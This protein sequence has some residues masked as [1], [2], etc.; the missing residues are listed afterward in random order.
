MA[1]NL[2]DERLVYLALKGVFQGQDVH[3]RQE[4]KVRKLIEKQ[5]NHTDIKQLVQTYS[6]D[7]LCQTAKVLLKDQVFESTLKAK[8]R[9]PEVFEVSPDQ[10]AERA[11]SEYE[12]SKHEDAAIQSVAEGRS[13]VSEIPQ[14]KLPITNQNEPTGT[15]IVS[16]HLW[17][18]TQTLTPLDIL[19]FTKDCRPASP[20]TIITCHQHIPLPR[21]SPL[22]YPTSPPRAHP[23]HP[24]SR[25]LQVCFQTHAHHP[26]A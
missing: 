19:S 12:A 8:I 6:L 7:S 24:R 21:L 9:F 23:N 1:K 3:V 16:F 13:N 5:Q 17:F 2:P 18:N 10:T 14:D 4:K 15:G 26:R 11:I 20:Y 22:L 25:M